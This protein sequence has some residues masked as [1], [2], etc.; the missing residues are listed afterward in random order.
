[1]TLLYRDYGIIEKERLASL[2][3]S[4]CDLS[5]NDAVEPPQL[6][7]ILCHVLMFLKMME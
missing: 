6:L 5:L 3:P 1:M 7:Q 4:Y 2:G